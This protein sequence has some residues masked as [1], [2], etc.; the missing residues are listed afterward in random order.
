MPLAPVAETTISDWR[1]RLADLL[2][3]PA[4]EGLWTPYPKQQLATELAAE[5]DETLFGGAAGPGKTEWGLRH[6][7]TQMERYPGNRGGIFRRVYPSLTRSV[8]PRLK[9]LLWK[10]A[11]WNGNEHTFTFPNGSILEVGSLQYEDSVLDFQGAEYGVIFFEEITEFLQ[12]QWEYMLGRLRPPATMDMAV[13]KLMRP[14]GIATTNPGG[15]GHRWVKRRWVKPDPKDLTEGQTRPGPYKIWKPKA[16]QDQDPERVNSRV[17]IP[18][19]HADNPALLEKDPGYLAR[20]QAN[21]NRGLRL[22]MEHGDWDAIDAII[23]ALWRGDEIDLGRVSP[24]WFAQ[25][26]TTLRRVV[27]V[28]PSDGSDDADPEASKGD[29]FGICVAS[30]GMDGV[31]YVEMSDEWHASTRKMAE[32]TIDIYKSV[33]ADALVIERNHGGKW[34]LEVFRSID[35]YVN[36]VDVWASDNKRT[37]AEPV[38]ALF[39]PNK[40]RPDSP[41]LARMVG[42]HD[43]LEEELTTTRFDTGERSPNQLDAMVWAMSELMLGMGEVQES[44]VKD[45]RHRGRR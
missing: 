43:K 27:A 33:G 9:I 15:R 11:R 44:E 45:A 18:A 28:D 10:K 26:V 16:R 37:R 21:S 34:M 17:Y 14:H 23:G 42:F 32:R 4:T 39:E 22:A 25:K 19:T 7:I 5:A 2:D 41:F 24:L 40:R 29:A 38:A 6:V 1:S 12:S 36:V 35:P 8:I 20:L 13:A 3:P 31:G 30:K